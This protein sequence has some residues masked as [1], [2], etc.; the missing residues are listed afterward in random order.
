METG[1]R[2]LEDARVV[3]PARRAAASTLSWTAVL[4]HLEVLLSRYLTM[5]LSKLLCTGGR[6]GWYWTEVLRMEV[7]EASLTP[8]K[9]AA[10]RLPV[11]AVASTPAISEQ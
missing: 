4:L 2:A 5:K 7:L 8:T 10:A 9:E 3:N 1:A 11:T 6:S